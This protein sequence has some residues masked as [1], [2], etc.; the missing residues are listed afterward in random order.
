MQ[1]ISNASHTKAEGS[2]KLYAPT[3]RTP[4]GLEERR[5]WLR[6]QLY[7]N[8]LGFRDITERIRPPTEQQK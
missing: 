5:D 8:P 3:P 1:I 2:A 6:E 7:L 4:Q